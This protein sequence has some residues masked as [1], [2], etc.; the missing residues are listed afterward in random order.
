MCE[1]SAQNDEEYDWLKNIP[2]NETELKTK[3]DF[4]DASTSDSF[5]VHHD[6]E[7]NHR[8][9]GIVWKPRDD[10]KW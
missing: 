10:V 8:V 4:V 2:R 1:A 6:Q 9:L 7:N 3:E 5:E